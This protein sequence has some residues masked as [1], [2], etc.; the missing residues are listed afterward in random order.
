MV[1]AKADHPAGAQGSAPDS[2][3]QWAGRGGPP[4]D[5]RFPGSSAAGV[6]LSPLLRGSCLLQGP[7][8]IPLPAVW[9]S[10]NLNVLTAVTGHSPGVPSHVPLLPVWA[11]SPALGHGTESPAQRPR[12]LSGTP[13]GRVA[14]PPYAPWAAGSSR[15]PPNAAAATVDLSA[16]RREGAGR[17]SASLPGLWR[18]PRR[19]REHSLQEGRGLG[20]LRPGRAGAGRGV[21][22]L[23]RLVP[24]PPPPNLP[25]ILQPDPINRYSIVIC[26]QGGLISQ[27]APPLLPWQQQRCQATATPAAAAAAEQGWLYSAGPLPC[28]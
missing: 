24:G 7:D 13:W 22:S 8:F 6:Q 11:E 16:G 3:G 27:L 18:C 20:R 5:T 25:R 14:L 19:R 1:A 15:L 9:G 21:D 12:T 23:L 26:S 28:S 10:C 2:P 17:A 4:T